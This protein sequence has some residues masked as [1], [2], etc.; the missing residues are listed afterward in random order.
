MTLFDFL[1]ITETETEKR[2]C[3]NLKTLREKQPELYELI[4]E[5]SELQKNRYSLF[6]KNLSKLDNDAFYRMYLETSSTKSE[7]VYFIQNNITGLIKIG[8]T[9]NPHD[10]MQSIRT[11]LRTATG[12]KP[13]LSFVGIIRTT[14]SSMYD[15]EKMLHLK[16]K[17]FRNYGEWFSIDKNTII[18][19]YFSDAFNVNGIPFAIEEDY[20]E[21]PDDLLHKDVSD[22]FWITETIYTLMDKCKEIHKPIKTNNTVLEMMLYYNKD[23]LL[24]LLNLDFEKIYFNRIL[25]KANLSI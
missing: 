24:D 6:R 22:N 19:N 7:Y 10:R 13:D 14:E 11:T 9:T 21:L 25:E 12:V 18:E 1:G 23:N 17:E 20:R 5:N 4:K 2:P 16:Y 8:A 3:V 15:F